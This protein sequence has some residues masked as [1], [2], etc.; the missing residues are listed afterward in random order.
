MKGVRTASTQS[1]HHPKTKRKNKTIS[2][3]DLK[4]LIS[5]AAA[6]WLT[7]VVHR[8]TPA[9]KRSS[10]CPSHTDRQQ[11][12]ALIRAVFTVSL[13]HSGSGCGKYLFLILVVHRYARGARDAFAQ[14]EPQACHQLLSGGG[15]AWTGQL[16]NTQIETGERERE[17]E[18]HSEPI[19]G[20][21]QECH[22][23]C[24]SLWTPNWLLFICFCKLCILFWRKNKPLCSTNFKPS[25]SH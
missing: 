24:K 20:S 9:L 11:H 5:N 25:C 1:S 22:D 15:G 12:A 17:R 10:L 21:D 7:V 13:S 8:H 4:F 14:Q 6:R 16:W 23:S 19:A 3:P 2:G 18:R